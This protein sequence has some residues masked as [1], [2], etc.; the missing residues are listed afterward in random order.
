MVLASTIQL[1]NSMERIETILFDL[2]DTLV[3]Y[4]RS[5][6]EV[7]QASFNTLGSA[8]LFTV[9]EYYARYDEFAEKCDTMDELRSECF[10]ALAA[11]NGYE[12]QLGRDVADRFSDERDQ[13]NVELLP[14]AARVLT[15]LNR[16]YKLAIVTNGAQDAQHQK[17]GAVSL[18]KWVDTIIVAGHDVPP[19]PDPEPFERAI[20]SLHSTPATTIHVGDSVETDIAGASAAGIDSIWISDTEKAQG[21]A[22]THRIESLDDLLSLPKIAEP[23][24]GP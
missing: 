19:K 13:T 8:P 24:S 23:L 15:E 14:S 3:R 2:D 16:E 6:G 4:K 20:Q 10:A 1:D 5:P 11:E 18:E 17:I 7:L 12:R 22:P 9:E 21:Y